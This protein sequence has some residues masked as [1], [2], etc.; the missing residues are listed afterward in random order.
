MELL[1]H[2]NSYEAQRFGVCFVTVL[3]LGGFVFLGPHT[4]TAYMDAR[5]AVFGE[6]HFGVW[7]GG[8]VICVPRG[9]T[10]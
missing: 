7:A 2:R 10:G 5:F 9:H 1:R 4:R 8:I 3:F 6:S